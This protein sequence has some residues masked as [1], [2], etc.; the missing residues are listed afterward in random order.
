M[1][2][3]LSTLSTNL[4]DMWNY[5]YPAF[6]EAIV[7]KKWKI[8][9]PRAWNLEVAQQLCPRHLMTFLKTTFCA[10]FLASPNSSD[11]LLLAHLEQKILPSPEELFILMRIFKSQ[12]SHEIS[13]LRRELLSHAWHAGK[14]GQKNQPRR[15]FHVF[16][17][18][19]V[20]LDARI[21]GQLSAFK[22][23]H[24]A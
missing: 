1:V 6:K 19:G 17:I 18:K 16:P 12:I 10:Q 7:A 23:A 4:T 22:V 14:N 9:A 3:R 5:D 21:I 24:C 15:L 8:Y 2:Q 20:A 13:L 11:N